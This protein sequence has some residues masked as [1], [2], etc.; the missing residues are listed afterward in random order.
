MFRQQEDPTEVVK[1]GT[2]PED[3][4]LTSAEYEK[5]IAEASK[6]LR[7]NTGDKDFSIVSSARAQQILQK[8]LLGNTQEKRNLQKEKV[9]KTM[10]RAKWGISLVSLTCG[11]LMLTQVLYPMVNKHWEHFQKREA[12][13]I[14]AAGEQQLDRPP[15]EPK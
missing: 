5:R 8:G 6:P 1:R 15:S 9:N 2:R 14:R 3:V 13:R 10:S 11:V 7:V 12:R 4:G